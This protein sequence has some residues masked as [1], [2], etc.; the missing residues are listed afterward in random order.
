MAL[1]GPP[2]LSLL[3]LHFLQERSPVMQ[4]LTRA[5]RASLLAV[6]LAAPGAQAQ[7][8]APGASQQGRSCEITL[9]IRAGL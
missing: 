4:V 9:Q 5:A 3:A 6:A 7:S 8:T 2:R 1:T